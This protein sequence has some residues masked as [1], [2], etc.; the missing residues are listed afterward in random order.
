[1]SNYKGKRQIYNGLILEKIES[2]LNKPDSS[3]LR[4][5]QIIKIAMTDVTTDLFYIESDNLLELLNS[6][7][8]V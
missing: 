2:I 8:P 4:I 5:G 7:F 3:D 1:M 6:K